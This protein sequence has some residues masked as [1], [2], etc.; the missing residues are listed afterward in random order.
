LSQK[1]TVTVWPTPIGFGAT[2]RNANVDMLNGGVWAET[3]EG[4]ER[5]ITKV[6]KRS[7]SAIAI[8]SEFFLEDSIFFFP[9]YAVTL[10]TPIALFKKICKRTLELS[11]LK[12]EQKFNK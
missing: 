10:R 6:I 1:L 5:A 3:K 8:T 11:F 7:A 12:T 9:F 2:L 4:I